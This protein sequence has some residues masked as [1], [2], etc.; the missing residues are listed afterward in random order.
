MALP[1]R[2]LSAFAILTTALIALMASFMVT[3]KRDST[4]Y[5]VPNPSPYFITT[6]NASSPR[7]K[8][9]R[10]EKGIFTEVL[11]YEPT[12][13]SEKITRLDGF[14]LPGIIESHGHILQYGEMLESVSLYGAQSVAEIRSRI[15]DFLTLHK[16]EDYGTRKK[17][18]RGIG[19]DQAYFGGIMPTA[20]CSYTLILF[21]RTNTEQFL[22]RTLRRS[23][24][25]RSLHHA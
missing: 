7:A 9:F 21:E 24:V 18:I 16:G 17:W 13:K 2:G 6:L 20:V 10:I 19:W 14:V 15:K 8:C 25:E 23:V 1:S 11:N 5:C 22:G 12:S 3:D 4:V